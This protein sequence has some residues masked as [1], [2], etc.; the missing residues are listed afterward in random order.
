MLALVVL[1]I[2]RARREERMLIERYADDALR[3]SRFIPGI[4]RLG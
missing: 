2:S 1:V 4:G 3:V